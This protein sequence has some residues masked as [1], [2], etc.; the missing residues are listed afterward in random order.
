MAEYDSDSSFEEEYIQNEIP[1]P[2]IDDEFRE[3]I[4]DAKRSL[5]TNIINGPELGTRESQDVKLVNDYIKA[6]NNLYILSLN[7]QK[8]INVINDRN[9][10]VFPPETKE[11]IELALRYITDYFKKLSIVDKI[12]YEHYIRQS[13]KE[14]QFLLHNNFE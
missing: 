6:L 5:N 13:F 1:P 8:G 14:N 7:A 10:S 3:K 9:L 12:P 4:L 11:K 2:D